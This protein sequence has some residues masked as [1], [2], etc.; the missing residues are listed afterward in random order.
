MLVLSRKTQERIQIGD[1]VVVTVLRV[2]G[3]MVRIGIE[4]PKEVRVMRAELPQHE[5]GVREMNA[6]EPK[7]EEGQETPE[8]R[9][10]R[11]GSSLR[12]LAEAVLARR[13]ELAG[14]SSEEQQGFSEKIECDIVLE[15]EELVA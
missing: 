13:H 6:A 3:N 4:A 7:A 12:K 5:K 14:S 2:K 1:N 10:E 11:P 15:D 8:V 9:V